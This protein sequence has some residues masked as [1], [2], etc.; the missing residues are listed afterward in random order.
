MALEEAFGKR[1]S[2]GDD[3]FGLLADM[4]DH[5][6][7]LYGLWSRALNGEAFTVT[8]MFGEKA[9]SQRYYE[10]RFDTLLDRGGTQIGAVST[11]YDVT[12]R[13]RAEAGLDAARS[14]A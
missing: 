9:L 12:A 3:L 5:R 2:I 7:Q 8:Q 14:M 13:M 11:S 6:L 10:M 4:P 1:P